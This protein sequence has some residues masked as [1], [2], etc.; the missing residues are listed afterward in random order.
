VLSFW[1]VLWRRRDRRQ[2]TLAGHQRDDDG[3]GLIDCIVAMVILLAV[4]IP[5]SY[6]FTNVLANAAS[7]RQRL[8]ALS[9]A[10]QWIE[11]LNNQGP[12]ADAN[13]QPEVGVPI[14]EPS[15]LLSGVT[16]KVVA[17]FHWTDASGGTPDFCATNT[18]PALGLQ[19]TVSWG[20]GQSITDQ[21][22]LD[23]PPSGNLTDG[24]LAVQ[25]NG[26]PSYP[27]TPPA[28]VFSNSWSSRVQKVPVQISGS[29]LTT[30][31]ELTPDAKGCV[32]LELA[33][34][35]Y[36][37]QVGP[38][39]TAAYVANYN[40]APSET[41]ALANQSPV[42]V[43]VAEITEV[44]FQ[45][46]EGADVGLSY[47]TSTAVADGITCPHRGPLICLV[48]GQSPANASAPSSSPQA[49][50]IVETL[51]GWAVAS[52]PSS[53]TRIKGVDCTASM[54]FAV[55]YGSSGAAAAVTTN[56]SSWTAT[57]L[58]A[59]LSALTGV[60]CPSGAT[61]PEC[62]AIGS[63]ISSN[64]VLLTATI[65]GSAVTWTQDT[66]PKTTSLQQIVC[67][68]TSLQ[69]VCFVVATTSSGAIIFSN[70]GSPAPGTSWTTYTTQSGFTMSSITQLA[71]NSTTFCVAI[72][73]AQPPPPP[74]PGPGPPPP[75]PPP[76]PGPPPPPPPPPT[77]EII[78][79][80]NGTWQEY[81]NSTGVTPSAFNSIAC[82]S[83]GSHC[84]A[85]G[86]AGS[87]AIAVYLTSG[88]TWQADS[89]VPS[90][91]TA[92]SNLTCP[93]VTSGCFALYQ[94]PSS[95]GVMAI[96]SGT[97]WST[98]NLPAGVVSMEQLVCPS[99]S[100][101]FAVGTS[102][103]SAVVDVLASGSWSS[104]SFAATP[105]GTPVYVTGL[106]CTAA[107]T[108]AAAAATE[109][110]GVVLT[111]SNG[112]FSGASTPTNLTGMFLSNPP[113]MVSNPNLQPDT[114]IEMAAPTTANGPQFAVGPLFPFV[115][116]YSIAVGY[117]PSELTTA[118]SSAS[119]VPG[120][121]LTSSPA[122][123]T[124]TLPMGLL[125]I[126]ATNASGA[127]ISGA[128]ISIADASCTS[129]TELTP[130]SSGSFPALP[131][132]PANPSNPANYTMPTSGVDGLSRIAVIYGTYLVTVT[133]GPAHA[134]TAVTVNPTSIVV[135][136][137][138][139]YMPAFVP[140]PD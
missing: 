93:G 123:P 127:P 13:N 84:W 125:P 51:S 38:G 72:G 94:T 53:L 24:F 57:A 71:C 2:S 28:D 139:Y 4:L 33:P 140:V 6:L 108:C 25:V 66:I 10:E 114:T 116:G 91:S 64:G 49:T 133:L 11:V 128:T 73:V 132:P 138:T 104:A 19:V 17:F 44:E 101:C 74:P 96:G 52:L 30:P 68:S 29:N 92:L 18:A 63:G 110:A 121:T 47:P 106:A 34:G 14:S 48:A 95:A 35:V 126:E 8:T 26:D 61:T 103:Q 136:S 59:G 58:P 7:A 115:S 15:S 77:P 20:S 40:E 117:C 46:D 120:A 112:T 129:S 83:S 131:T 45:Y 98:A 56:G 69:P 85:T 62:V 67:P 16:Y 55:G 88:T 60:V 79:L 82:T 41:Q 99:T 37:V 87:S 36:N 86:T 12:P 89:G 130:L 21:A 23:F 80:V 118:S 102:A 39:P 22:I 105:G 124:V 1:R 134:T 90:G 9:V 97:T 81:T 100:S 70:S 43:T 107:T 5:T 122:A 78:Q 75:P 135:G 54:C 65:S 32:F 31:Y 111:Y 137:T 42:T 76:G 3:F 119:T 50:A 109:T 27:G 113:I